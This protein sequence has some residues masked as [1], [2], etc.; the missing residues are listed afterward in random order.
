MLNPQEPPCP[1]SPPY[2][3]RSPYPSGQSILRDYPYFTRPLLS[4]RISL[5]PQGLLSLRTTLY[6]GKPSYSTGP[7]LS[8]LTPPFRRNPAY[9]SEIPYPTGPLLSLGTF[10]IPHDPYSTRALFHAT[11]YPSGPTLFFGTHLILRDL[12][13]LRITLITRDSLSHATVPIP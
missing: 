4:L 8:V 11:P 3:P 5:I 7:L 12:P 2:P 1:S 9:P 6:L 13:S 10:L